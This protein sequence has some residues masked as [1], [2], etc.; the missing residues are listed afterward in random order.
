LPAARALHILKTSPL[1]YKYVGIFD[2][3]CEGTNLIPEGI[4]VPLKEK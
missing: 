3:S 2:D 4:L 1:R